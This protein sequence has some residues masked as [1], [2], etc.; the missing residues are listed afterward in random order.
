M[1]APV[2]PA[3]L[4][5]GGAIV[6]LER[7]GEDEALQLAF[8]SPCM[9]S[10]SA[11]CAGYVPDICRRCTRE[12]CCLTRRVRGRK[13]FVTTPYP[14]RDAALHCL[15]HPH[16]HFPVPAGTPDQQRTRARP[17]MHLRVRIG[18]P[19]RRARDFHGLPSRLRAPLIHFDCRARL[20][21]EKPKDRRR[22]AC[23]ACA[24]AAGG[25]GG[26]N[27]STRPRAGGG[28]KAEPVP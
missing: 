3:I 9:T 5:C 27:S 12:T 8:S 20:P 11:S 7:V 6:C 1:K 18:R 4:S 14:H 24:G 26:G 22:S 13:R 2:Y 23:E 21:P 15:L 17:R 16:E 25:G 28:F 10:T 19:S